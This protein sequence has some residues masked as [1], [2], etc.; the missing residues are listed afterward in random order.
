M[1]ST[2]PLSYKMTFHMVASSVCALRIQLHRRDLSSFGYG[3]RPVH[4]NMVLVMC[5]EKLILFSF[6]F[7]GIVCFFNRLH[8]RNVYVGLKLNILWVNND[9]KNQD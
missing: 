4:H 3:S 8:F 9:G 5:I 1:P 2:I 7:M 6:E